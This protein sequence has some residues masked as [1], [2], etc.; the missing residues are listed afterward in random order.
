MGNNNINI[1][2]CNICNN[3]NNICIENV[4]NNYYIIVGCWRPG[5]NTSTLASLLYWNSRTYFCS[6]LC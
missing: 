2:C 1:C 5:Q 3:N 6:R 4:Y